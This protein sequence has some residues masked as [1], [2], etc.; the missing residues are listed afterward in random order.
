[1][2]MD[3]INCKYEAETNGGGGIYLG[4]IHPLW[5]LAAAGA[6]VDSL[7]KLIHIDGFAFQQYWDTVR[8]RIQDLAIVGQQRLA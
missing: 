3:L 6:R 5:A 1:M 8:D 4:A 2:Q 7:T